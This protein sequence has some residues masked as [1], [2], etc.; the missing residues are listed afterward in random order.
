MLASQ[1]ISPSRLL[2]IGSRPVVIVSAWASTTNITFCNASNA[3]IPK[4][5]S[6]DEVEAKDYSYQQCV[7]LCLRRKS[8]RALL[9]RATSNAAER[10][11]RNRLYQSLVISRLPPQRYHML[12]NGDDFLCVELAFLSRMFGGGK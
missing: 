8:R 2:S 10:C 6:P 12:T 3:N 11:F 5:K 1:Y 7:H 9:L 4:L